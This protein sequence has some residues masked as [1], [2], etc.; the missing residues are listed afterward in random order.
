MWVTIFFQISQPEQT[1]HLNEKVETD[2]RGNI[3][4]VVFS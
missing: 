1:N 2:D 3:Q 4:I